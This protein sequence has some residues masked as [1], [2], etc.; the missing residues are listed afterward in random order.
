MKARASKSL[1]QRDDCDN[2][3]PFHPYSG[4]S[5]GQVHIAWCG[6]E[7]DQAY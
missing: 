5:V 6:G 3:P 2:Q 4:E 1:S 7:N